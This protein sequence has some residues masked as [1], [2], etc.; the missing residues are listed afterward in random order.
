MRSTIAITLVLCVASFAAA[1]SIIAEQDM[2]THESYYAGSWTDNGDG[3]WS[4]FFPTG[5]W[6]NQNYGTGAYLSLRNSVGPGY[7]VLTNPY[8]S[9]WTEGMQSANYENRTIV[10]FDISGLVGTQTNGLLRLAQTGWGG[11]RNNWPNGM[12]NAPGTAYRMTKAISDQ[13]TSSSYLAGASDPW[14]ALNAEGDYTTADAVA[15]DITEKSY[16]NTNMNPYDYIDV[17]AML[18]AAIADG[19]SLLTVILI[20]DQDGTPLVDGDDAYVN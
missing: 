6:L 18:N 4:P 8:G 5:H 15:F 17:L 7:N 9:S 1:Q 13:A 3:T 12:D 2:F 16:N 10:Q 19:D 14:S 11:N 20:A